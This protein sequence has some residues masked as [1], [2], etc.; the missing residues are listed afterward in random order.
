MAAKQE[1]A[2]AIG[3]AVTKHAIAASVIQV[4]ESKTSIRTSNGVQVDVRVVPVESFGAALQYFTGNTA[5]NVKLRERAIKM[6][7]KL[8]EWGV[9]RVDGKKEVR[10]AGGTEQ[11]FYEALGLAWMPPEM[12]EDRGEVEWAIENAKRE[13]RNAKEKP[14]AESRNPKKSNARG[15]RNAEEKTTD[16]RSRITDHDSHAIDLV[17]IANIRGDLHTHTVGLGWVEFH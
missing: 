13:T 3:V 1:D 11:G 4:G 8:N 17:E 14:K 12:R 16:H 2:A 10:I 7:L 6:G 9:Y 5:H 15:A